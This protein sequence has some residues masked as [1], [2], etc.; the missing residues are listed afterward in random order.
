MSD[1]K[2]PL[3]GAFLMSNR[4]TYFSEPMK[5]IKP[6][7]FDEGVAEV[8][9]DMVSRSVPFYHEIHRI[10][11]DLL[12]YY[13][14]DGDSIYDFGCSTGTTI[15]LMSKHLWDKDARFVGVDNSAAMIAKAKAKLSH[16]WHPYELVTDDIEAVDLFQAGVV[17]MNYTLQFIPKE[18]RPALL[19][20]IYSGLRPGGIFIFTEKI[21]SEDSEI[22]EL[23]TTLYY[24]FKK[25][26]GY[27]ELEIAQKREALE[28]V[29]V[30]HTPESQLALLKEAGFKKN[31]MIFRWYNF[32]CFIGIKDHELH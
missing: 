26:Q 30:P 24:D 8:F 6:F 20:K 25:R 12:N 31:A 13:F 19:K 15:E 9:D 7:V 10:I 23:L 29:L 16:L 22:H 18:R 1:I 17:V 14:K 4:D 27:S 11:K 28:R 21:D 32:A 3:K 5:E 2:A